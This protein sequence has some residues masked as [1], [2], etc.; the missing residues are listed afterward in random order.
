MASNEL[1]AKLA[2]RTEIIEKAEQLAAE[3]GEEAVLAANWAGQMKINNPYSEFKQFSRKQLQHFQKMF[4]RYG[5]A[6]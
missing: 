2:R 3:E 1:A 6:R 5:V 4:N